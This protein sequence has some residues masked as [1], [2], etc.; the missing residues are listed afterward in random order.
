MT[1]HTNRG[2]RPSLW[3]DDGFGHL[4]RI[5]FAELVTRIVSGWPEH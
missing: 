4:T 2:C 1:L 3:V 5:T